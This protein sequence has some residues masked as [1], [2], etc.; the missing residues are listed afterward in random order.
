MNVRPIASGSGGNAILLQDGAHRLLLDCGLPWRWLRNAIG[1]AP[2]DGILLTHEHGD[3][4][5][6]VGTALRFGHVVAATPGT[7]TALGVS[8]IFA[9]AA[10]PGQ[11]I[12]L[13]PWRAVPVPTRHDGARQPCAWL[14]GSPSGACGAYVCDAPYVHNR[15]GGVTH[16][17]VEAN[18]DPALLAAA[19]LDEAQSH[20]IRAGHMSIDQAIAL[21]GA[22]DHSRSREIWLLH[23]SDRHADAEAFRRRVQGATGLPCHIAPSRR[24]ACG[25]AAP[26]PLGDRPRP[27]ARH[28]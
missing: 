8:S 1:P 21:L 4:A 23:L 16:W 26:M 13:G 28:D 7:L 10:A 3:H 11:Q 19:R 22:N 9:V 6:G 5:R 2:L 27:G 17:M 20:H 12:A 14:V 18:Y 15:L 24:E 25:S